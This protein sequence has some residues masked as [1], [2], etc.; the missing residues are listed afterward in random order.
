MVC[1]GFQLFTCLIAIAS[2]F[3]RRTGELAFCHMFLDDGDIERMRSLVRS[4]GVDVNVVQRF[5]AVVFH[6]GA[7]EPEQALKCDMD[8]DS[9]NALVTTHFGQLDA[10]ALSQ[11]VTRVLNVLLLNK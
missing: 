3:C 9:T 2:M 4:E 11:K 7:L 1:V 8:I 10:E 5:L 6:G